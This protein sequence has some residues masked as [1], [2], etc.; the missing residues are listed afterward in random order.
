MFKVILILSLLAL[1]L[2]AFLRHESSA[3]A[4][5]N[6][7]SSVCNHFSVDYDE[8]AC[9]AAGGT[10]PNN[11][12][13]GNGGSLGIPTCPSGNAPACTVCAGG[14]CLEACSGQ[15]TCLKNPASITGAC[16][17]PSGPGCTTM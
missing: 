2:F 4:L 8:E 12:G 11:G 13:F 6:R 15:Y 10:N 14:K 1:S 17:P 7:T 3:R 9:F 5:I 16:L